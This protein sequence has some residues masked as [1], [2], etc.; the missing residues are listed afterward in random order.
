LGVVAAKQTEEDL[1][2]FLGAGVTSLVR[3]K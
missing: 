2:R 1:G 3:V